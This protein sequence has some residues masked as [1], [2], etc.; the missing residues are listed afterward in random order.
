M[1]L[2]LKQQVQLIQRPSLKHFLWMVRRFFFYF[3]FIFFYFFT[4][5]IIILCVYFFFKRVLLTLISITTLLYFSNIFD[6]KE[7]IKARAR[8]DAIITVVDAR[9]CLPKLREVRPPEVEVEAIE[10]VAFA[11]LLLLNKIDL[12]SA[13]DL[14]EGKTRRADCMNCR[15]CRC[16]LVLSFSKQLFFFLFSSSFSSFSSFLLLCCIVFSISQLKRNYAKRIKSH[17]LYIPHNATSTSPRSLTLVPLIQIK[18]QKWIQN[19][20]ILTVNINMM[21]LLS[22]LAFVAQEIVNTFYFCL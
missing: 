20:Q 3:F 4:H 9:H 1:R 17:L 15:C 2:L 14:V 19:F 6:P 16:F 10:Q 7:S 18:C 22:V 8:L 11:D 12:V 5:D 21:P 13:E